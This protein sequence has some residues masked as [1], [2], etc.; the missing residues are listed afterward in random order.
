MDLSVLAQLMGDPK[1]GAALQPGAFQVQRLYLFETAIGSSPSM[2]LL[3]QRLRCP[4]SHGEEASAVRVF[5]S[6][7]ALLSL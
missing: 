5:R 3:A 2:T 4:R 6:L 7:S 1:S